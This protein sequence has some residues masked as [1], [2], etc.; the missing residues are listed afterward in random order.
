[1]VISLNQAQ[2][3]S[4]IKHRKSGNKG[5]HKVLLSSSDRHLRVMAEAFRLQSRTPSKLLFL[6]GC[7][8]IPCF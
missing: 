5:E 1:M 4:R 3:V 8:S 7:L 6:G 2:F